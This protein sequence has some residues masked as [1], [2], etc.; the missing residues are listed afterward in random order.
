MDLHEPGRSLRSL[1]EYEHL[2][3]ILRICVVHFMRKIRSAA[4]P[5]AVRFMMRSLICLE[6][7]SW[8]GTLAS[9]KEHGGKA[10]IGKLIPIL[11]LYFSNTVYRLGQRQRV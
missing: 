4:G 3:R 11:H 9:I 8:E 7:D 5:D 2:H 6:H 1:S 10:G